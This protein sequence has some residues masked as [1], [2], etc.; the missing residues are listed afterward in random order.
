MKKISTNNTDRKFHKINLGKIK[1]YPIAL[2]YIYFLLQIF[3]CTEFSHGL[4][5]AAR[6]LCKTPIFANFECNKICTVKILLLIPKMK[7]S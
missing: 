2:Q 4:F 7:F 1:M 6:N 3:F 5:K